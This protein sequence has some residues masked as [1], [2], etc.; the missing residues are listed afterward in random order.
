[1]AKVWCPFAEKWTGEVL[2]PG[3][4]EPGCLICGAPGHQKDLDFVEEQ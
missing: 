3:D 2:E 1:M 4:Q